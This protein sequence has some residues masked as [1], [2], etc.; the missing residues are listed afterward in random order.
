MNDK[1]VILN[2]LSLM[3]IT[4]LDC[5]D[6]QSPSNTVTQTGRG[7]VIV[8]SILV[9]HQLKISILMS[10]DSDLMSQYIAL[11]GYGAWKVF[12]NNR[13]VICRN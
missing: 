11:G 12:N 6:H 5:R 1:D 4:G 9:T 10:M 3:I 2:I 13:A 7:V 8:Y